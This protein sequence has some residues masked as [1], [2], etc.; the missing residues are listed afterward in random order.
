MLRWEHPALT[1]YRSK[2]RSAVVRRDLHR[3]PASS[4]RLDQTRSGEKAP[5]EDADGGALVVE[6]RRLRRDDVEKAHRA[7]LVLIEREN[8]RRARLARRP[9]VLALP[10]RECAAPRGCPRLPG[11]RRARSGGTG[12][13][14]RRRRRP[15]GRSARAADPRR[16][17]TA[18]S[19]GPPT[20]NGLAR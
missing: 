19:P 18:R 17:A 15:P 8:Y 10:P 20:R 16:K 14:P 1:P 6:L 5:A 7:R 3:A 11:I 2:A 9:P 13:P 4:Q 12:Q